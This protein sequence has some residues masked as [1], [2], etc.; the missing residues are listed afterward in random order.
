[1]RAAAAKLIMTAAPLSECGRAFGL[2]REYSA[3]AED[4]FNDANLP[5]QLEGERDGFGASPMLRNEDRDQTAL[6]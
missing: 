3:F 1:L 4:V 2:A 5:T 6:S